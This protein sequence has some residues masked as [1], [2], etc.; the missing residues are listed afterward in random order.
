MGIDAEYRRMVGWPNRRFVDLVGSEHPIIQAPMANAGGV[1]LCIAASE[2]GALGS[3]PCGMLN[4]GQMREQVAA[5]SAR[6]KAPLNLN[7]FCHRMP[8]RTDD[9]AWRA[10][11][12]PFYEE[13]GLAEPPD[14]PLRLP[15]DDAACAVVE[16]LKP[17]VVSFH[18]GLPDQPLLHRVKAVGAI[19]IGCAT[20]VEEALQLEQRGV[21][22]LIAQGFEAGGHTGRFLGSD[23]AEA[24]GLFALLPQVVD[25]I[26]IPVIAAGGIA[27][28]RGIAAA[29]ALGASAVQIGT[30]FLHCPE[31]LLPQE[32][33]EV[34]K[35]RSTVV[36][37]V[38]SGGLARAVRGRLID[39]IGPVRAEA[40]PYPLAG[41][42]TMPLFRAAIE[43]GDFEFLPMLA[44]QAAP[45]GQ[46]LPAAELTRRLA[47]DA[48]AII[49]G[50]D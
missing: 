14:G 27:D 45:L 5:V 12:Q 46:P 21:D 42:V 33:R 9:A 37:N 40:P 18:F 41:A 2:A 35:R 44:G 16:E 32:F 20:T 17:E 48:L 23:P 30:A 3:L 34:L 36:T 8:E 31:S 6:V 49:G 13:F 43:K 29:F 28:A 50:R 1:E 22:A 38:Y 25:A 10:L 4:P 19:V 47:A 11:L 7:F 39:E 26:R 15:F 24:L